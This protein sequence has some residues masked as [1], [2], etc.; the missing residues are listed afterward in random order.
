[1][2][3]VTKGVVIVPDAGNWPVIFQIVAES[4][5]TVNTLPI[6]PPVSA[7]TIAIPT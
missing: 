4:A 2:V 1:M 5:V 3:Y 6:N 7:E